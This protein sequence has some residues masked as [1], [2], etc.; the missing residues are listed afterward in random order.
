MKN[1]VYLILGIV[2]G[3]ILTK[4]EVISWFRIQE[5]FRFDSFHMYGVIGSALV[6]GVISL[7]IMKRVQAKTKDGET[8]NLAGK[9]L[10]W[11]TIIG[12]LIFG[13]GWAITGACPGPIFALIGNGNLVFILV[14]AFAIL[15]TWVY[16]LLK[17]KLPH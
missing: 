8:M 11:G 9:P 2:F 7:Q 16:G 10:N 17:D 5:M 6:V 4:T 12:G 14:L 1:T 13:L 3:F 15:G